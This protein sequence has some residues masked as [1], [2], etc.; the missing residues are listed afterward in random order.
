MGLRLG[1]DSGGLGRRKKDER[2]GRGSWQSSD[3]SLAAARRR[4]CLPARS[5]GN[6]LLAAPRQPAKGG[7]GRLQLLWDSLASTATL[8]ERLFV[9]RPRKSFA[10]QQLAAVDSL[11]YWNRLYLGTWQ[12]P[13]Q[14]D[15]PS[16]AG[17]SPSALPQ[18][19]LLSNPVPAAC[20]SPHLPEAEHPEL[21]LNSVGAGAAQ[22]RKVPALHLQH[23]ELCSPRV[24]PDVITTAATPGSLF[25]C[26]LVPEAPAAGAAPVEQL[27][28]S[29][30]PGQRL[31]AL[32]KPPFPSS[33]KEG[34]ARLCAETAEV[35]EF[36]SHS[37]DTPWRW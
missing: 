14:R 8:F 20:T 18:V 10:A 17:S 1:G 34:A 30:A 13:S 29:E 25:I 22:Q 19:W 36:V 26:S 6:A 31:A 15:S 24:G 5:D 35:G 23:R 12:E 16:P 3:A 9:A 37:S 33:W 32:P 7:G 4:G 27:S 28:H 2:E 11:L 21:L